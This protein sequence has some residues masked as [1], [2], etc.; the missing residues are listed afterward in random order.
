MLVDLLPMTL[1]GLL[2]LRLQP[3]DGSDRIR[4]LVWQ[5]NYV[6]VLPLAATYAFLS[7][8]LDAGTVSLFACA[9]AA[10]WLTIGASAAW[11]RT[12]ASTPTRR[13]ALTLIGGFPNTGFVGFPLAQLAFGSDGLRLAVIYDQVSLVVPAIVVAVVIARRHMPTA[14]D[15]GWADVRR[16]VLLSPPL[17]S[18]LVLLALRLTL[19]REPVELDLLGSIVG[20]VV[21]PIGFFLLGLSIPLHGF[22][23]SRRDAVQVGGAVAVRILVA[24][25]L[26]LA[27]TTLASVEVP[28]A[29]FLVVAMPTAFHVLVLSRLN[30]LETSAVRLGILASTAIVVTSTVVAVLMGI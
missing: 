29:M 5:A 7:I 27:V 17:W 25:L 30:D 26:L 23:H 13:G 22:D 28:H 15:A 10:W 14:A 21:G 9:V 3:R 18:V 19:V 11:A 8:D 20:H 1:A 16:Q 6:L 2:G 24:P 4:E 12:V